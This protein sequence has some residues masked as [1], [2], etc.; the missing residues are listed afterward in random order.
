[1]SGL[2]TKHKKNFLF[3]ILFAQQQERDVRPPW[4]V[5]YHGEELSCRVCVAN[6]RESSAVEH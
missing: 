4:I 5:S 3:G 1:M 2:D 6:S